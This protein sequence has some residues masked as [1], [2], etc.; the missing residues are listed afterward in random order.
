MIAAISS[1]LPETVLSNDE[2]ARLGPDWTPESIF[3]KTGIRERRVVAPGEYTSDL[4]VRAAERLFQSHPRDVDFLLLCTQ[5]PDYLL[6]TTACLVQDRLG[7]NNACGALDF[8]LGCSGYIYG[9]ALA[10]GLLHAGLASRLLL[11]TA[12]TYSRFLDPV[13]RGTR[14]IFGDGASATLLTANARQRLHSFVFG[15]DGSGA[16]HLIAR[17]SGLRAGESAARPASGC[18]FMN[19][20]EVF[21]F[22]IHEVPRLIDT[23]LSRAGIAHGDVDLFVFHQANAFM[24][25]HLRRKLGIPKEKFELCLEL[26]GNT[27]SSTIPL[28]LEGALAKGRIWPGARI[29]LAGFGV[30]LSWAGCVLEWGINAE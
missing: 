15:T 10:T 20:P 3:Q 12:D 7:L 14:S 24:L 16:S 1:Y 13:D 26:T 5:S 8:N 29:L 19:G 6:P 30:G 22:T 28:A 17:D 11:L 18:L 23:V 21:N 2:I 25:E 9:L 4:A 27:V